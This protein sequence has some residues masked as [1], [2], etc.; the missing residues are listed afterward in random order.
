MLQSPLLNKIHMPDAPESTSVNLDES[1][2]SSLLR[3]SGDPP[4]LTKFTRHLRTALKGQDIKPF[5]GLTLQRSLEALMKLAKHQLETVPA[6]AQQVESGLLSTRVRSALDPAEKW[7]TESIST[8]VWLRSLQAPPWTLHHLE[9]GVAFRELG[10]IAWQLGAK[11]VALHWLIARLLLPATHL[12][13]PTDHLSGD[14]VERLVALQQELGPQAVC[15]ETEAWR[16]L[17]SGYQLLR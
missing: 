4:L 9:A 13:Q 10:N 11:R 2:Y 14:D 17:Y 8:A 16:D 12:F 15:D 5:E 3:R 1:L 7:A 6:Y